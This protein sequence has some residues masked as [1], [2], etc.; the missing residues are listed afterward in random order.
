MIEK[1][2]DSMEKKG[3]KVVIQ[4][5]ERAIQ[6]LNCF[7]YAPEL[8]VS[9]IAAEL[10]LNKSTAFG[11]INTLATHGFLEQIDHNKNYRLGVVL[12]EFGNLA[13]SRFDLRR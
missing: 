8:G 1:V 5:V 6:I 3:S 2:V 10:G 12:F 4:S 7:R 13:I 11:L 9:E